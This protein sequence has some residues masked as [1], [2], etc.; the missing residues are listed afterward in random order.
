MHQ[1]AQYN[2][3]FKFRI[4]KTRYLSSFKTT[5]VN[6]WNKL[7]IHYSD[8]TAEKHLNIS[9]KYTYYYNNNIS[10]TWKIGIFQLNGKYFTCRCT[11]VFTHFAKIFQDLDENVLDKTC[12][13]LSST[14]SAFNCFCLCNDTNLC[15]FHIEHSIYFY[16]IEL[17]TK[18]RVKNYKTICYLRSTVFEILLSD[19]RTVLTCFTRLFKN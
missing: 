18:S 11:D 14:E 19:L 3:F 16:A 7:C 12:R 4:A 8:K 6:V 2:F 10:Y 15:F 17:S 9:K 13:Y 1:K 5:K